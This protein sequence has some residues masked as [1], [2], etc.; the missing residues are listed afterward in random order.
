MEQEKQKFDINKPWLT[1]D[2]WQLE[3]IRAKGNCF[4]LCGRQV[5]KST[6]ASIKA[7]ELAVHKHTKGEDILIIAYTEKQAYNLFFK[8]FNYASI[9]Y[10]HLIS[11]KAKEKPTKHEF[12]LN[13]VKIMCYAAGLMGEGLRGLTLKKIIIDEPRSMNDEV[14]TAVFPMVSVTGG[15]IDLLGTPGAKEGFFYMCSLRDDFQKFYV[16]AEDCPRHS[17]EFLEGQ[18]TI[19][20]ELR[21]AQEYLAMFLDDMRRFFP[22]EWIKKVCVLKRPN[23]FNKI[24]KTYLGVDVAG[25]GED[26]ITFEVIHKLNKDRFEQVE[27][28]ID[29]KKLTTQTTEKILQLHDG[30]KFDMI[31]VDDGGVGFGVFSELLREP[32]TRDKV[33]A[34]NNAKRFLSSD[35]K[36]KKKL[37]KE[38]MYY[39]LLLMGEQGKIK[40]LDDSNIKKSLQSV[41]TEVVIR[42]GRDSIE[43]I[44][45]DDTHIVE[46]LIRA[47]WVCTED[48]GLSLWWR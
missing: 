22:D 30:Y 13:G 43:R 31:G 37:M 12:V 28:I 24:G 38:E 33:K 7:V 34:L 17:K 29:R 23:S 27:N 8:A 10:P 26:E 47:N 15:S 39:R 32:R 3:Y 41:L 20:T 25:L 18:K 40:L 46:G 5:G 2:G 9:R 21:Y 19:L 35:K 16:S 6:A 42:E 45:G 4:L 11:K 48:E 1:L 14:F 36:E 44:Y